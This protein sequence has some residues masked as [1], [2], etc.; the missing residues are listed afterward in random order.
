MKCLEKD[1]TRRYESVSGL[2]GDLLRFL[3]NQPVE[4]GPPS[5]LYRLAKFAR[6]N[7]VALGTA[8]LVALSLLAGT[9]GVAWQAVRATRAEGQTM[10]ALAEARQRS[11]ETEQT[12]DYLI[13]DVFGAAAPQRAQGRTVTVQELMEKADV[14]ITERFLHQPR[15]EARCRL[16]LAEADGI[17]CEFGRA[18]RHAARAIAL[19]TKELGP[20][21]PDT[22]AARAAEA[23]AVGG[24]YNQGFAKVEE[25]ECL[26]RAL[27]ADVRRVLGPSHPL[28]LDV[29]SGLASTLELLRRLDEAETIA[30][31]ALALAEHTHGPRHPSTLSLRRSLA[32]VARSRGQLARAEDLLRPVVEARRQLLGPFDP[33]TLYDL[34]DLAIIVRQRGRIAEARRLYSEVLDQAWKSFGPTQIQASGPLADFITLLRAEHDYATIR[35]LCERWLRGILAM[36]VEAEAYQRSRR[37]VRSVASSGRWS[38]CLSRSRL[39]PSWPFELP[40]RTLLSAAAP[41]TGRCWG[42]VHRRAGR[43][44]GALRAMQTSE[45]KPT[46]E[47]WDEFHCV[48]LA[49]IHLDRGERDRAPCGTGGPVWR[50]GEDGAGTDLQVLR[51]EADVRLSELAPKTSEDFREIWARSLEDHRRRLGPKHSAT[52][53]AMDRLAD[54]LAEQGQDRQAATLL[55]AVQRIEPARYELGGAWGPWFPLAVLKLRDGN[56]D[57]FRALLAELLRRFGTTRDPTIAQHLSRLGSL[58]PST[59]ADPARFHEL[60]RI[61]VAAEGENPW[62]LLALGA[63]E[64]RAGEYRAVVDT[65][66]KARARQA[67]PA[68]VVQTM[69]ILAMAHTRLGDL[70]AARRDLAAADLAPAGVTSKLDQYGFALG[71]HWR[72]ATIAQILH[73]EAE[74]VL[75]DAVFPADPFAR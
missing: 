62:F 56:L 67:Y 69:S 55:E 17:L 43:L 47:G 2:A 49:L 72:E 53:G 45:Q 52:L 41:T 60:A 58:V 66:T 36:P 50:R 18:R 4:A 29:T 71:W 25:A 39:T 13:R 31:P 75:L 40:R 33:Q 48:V 35:D 26:Q 54:L 28:S 34:N 19:L 59:A 10:A 37:S 22:L 32:I 7:R 63:A 5:R 24:Q 46:W 11:D 51:A 42:A 64:Y 15:I 20:S 1:R 61:A 16:A 21:H 38:H 70:I 65:L 74:V 57:G 14:T 30:A 6:R 3:S 68:G 12:I 23:H 73:R 27:L 9:V 44:D 8:G